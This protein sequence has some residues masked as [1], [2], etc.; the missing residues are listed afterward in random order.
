VPTA[1]QA[2]G[3]TLE[4]SDLAAEVVIRW[5]GGLDDDPPPT[6]I[7]VENRRVHQVPAHIA[8]DLHARQPTLQQGGLSIVESPTMP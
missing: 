5:A 6:G 4:G 7:G 1:C 8:A 3:E 2:L